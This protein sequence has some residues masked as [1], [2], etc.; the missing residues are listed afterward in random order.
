M[1]IY[2]N[3]EEGRVRTSKLVRDWAQSGL[4][5]SAQLTAIDE[6]LRTDLRRTNIV[7]RIVLFLFTAMVLQSF[8]GFG[9]LLVDVRDQWFVGGVAIVAG[10][11]A[12]MLGEFL[13]TRLRFFRF[14]VEEACAMCAIALVTGGI[15]VLVVAETRQSPVTSVLVVASLAGLASYARYGYLYAVFGAMAGAAAVPFTLELPEPAA[16]AC[17][18]LVL[19]IIFAGVRS[20]RSATEEEHLHDEFKLLESAAWLGLYAVLN[21]KLTSDLWSTP[22]YSR[23]FVLGTYAAIWIL[24]SVGLG[25]GI[26]G[27]QRWMIWA[28]I[29]TALVT[30]ATNKMYLGWARHTWDPILLGLLLTGIA[31][32]VRRWLSAG[33]GGERAGF[34]PRRILSSDQQSLSMLSTVAGAAQPGTT[35]HTGTPTPDKFEPGGGASGGA[36]AS[37]RF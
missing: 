1:R 14:G 15:G 3:D 6:E 21:L 30:L 34:T 36:G 10:A 31:M 29:V 27:R 11:G 35:Q 5:E 25:L 37:G 17:S 20:L 26:R 23:T 19:L 12:T 8:V 7:L 13:I 16:R 24:P 33:P 9:L 18:A 22:A 2:S 4:I 28:N 32:G